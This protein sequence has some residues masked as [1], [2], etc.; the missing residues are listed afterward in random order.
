MLH[1]GIAVIVALLWTSPGQAQDASQGCS[2]LE[3]LAQGQPE[4]SR[5]PGPG[6]VPGMW[7]PMPTSRLMLC[8]VQELRLRRQELSL[9]E[10]QLELHR[11]QA[12]L[13]REQVDLAVEAEGRLEGVVTAAERRAK[14]AELAQEK[15]EDELDAWHRSPFLWFGVG[16]VTTIV[17]EV[18]AVM[19]LDEV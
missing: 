2:D 4:P 6:Q 16:I 5:L 14:D 18:A 12:V 13:L 3:G 1:L 8:E 9:A 17:L 11:D 19:V 15:A 7:F 10:Q